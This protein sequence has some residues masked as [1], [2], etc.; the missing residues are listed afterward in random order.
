MICGSRINESSFDW[1]FN[2]FDEF[3]LKR[4]VEW[5]SALKVSIRFKSAA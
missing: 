5:L 2:D 4:H 3:K 1:N